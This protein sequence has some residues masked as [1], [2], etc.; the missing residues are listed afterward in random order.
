MK[1]RFLHACPL[2]GVMTCLSSNR[3]IARRFFWIF[4]LASLVIL[5]PKPALAVPGPDWIDAGAFRV[6]PLPF[7]PAGVQTHQFC[8]YDRAG[9]NYDANYFPLY[10][11]TNGE[12]VIFDAMG[13]GCLYR[14]Q[15]NIWFG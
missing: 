6:D 2:G 11:E 5:T 1:T 7:L 14:Q 15:M 8:S 3:R 13:P 12:C 10:T 4:V 9:D